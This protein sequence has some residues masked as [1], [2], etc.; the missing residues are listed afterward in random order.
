M[1]KSR[2]EQTSL[3][4]F[5]VLC[6]CSAFAASTYAVDLAQIVTIRAGFAGRYKVGL[7]TPLQ[8]IVRGGSGAASIGAQAT[9]ADSD[10]LNCTFNSA[11]PCQVPFGQEANIPLCVRFGHETGSVKIDILDGDRSLATKTFVSSPKPSPEQ[12]SEAMRPGQRLIVSVGAVP[13]SMDTS[14]PS[15]EGASARNVLAAIDDIADLPDCWQGYEG[16]DFL[17]LSTGRRELLKQAAS[18]PSRIDALEQWVQMGGTLVLTAGENAE[19]AFGEKSPL[20]RFVPGRF[21]GLAHLHEGQVTGLETLAHGQNPIPPPRPDEKVDLIAARL[22]NVHGSVDARASNI[23][24]VVRTAH[25]LGQVVFVATDLDR[26]SIRA[27]SDRPLLL[28]SLLGLPSNELPPEA[29]TAVE[30]YGYDDL[31]GQLRSSLEQFAGVRMVPFFVVAILAAIYILLIAPGDYFLLRR[32]RRGMQW[33]WITFPA[34]V[35]LVAAGGYLASSWLKRDV[36]RVDQVDLIDIDADGTARGATW[37]G[38]FSPRS[39]TFD[40]AL[41]AHLPNG[42]MPKQTTASLGWFGKAG[43]AF[44]GMYNRDAQNSGPIASEGYSIGPTMDTARDVPIQNWSCKNFVYRWL[45][46]AGDQG[47][48][49]S[50][51]EEGHQPAGSIVNDLKPSGADGNKGVTLSHAFLAYDGWAYLLGTIRPGETKEIGASTRRVSLSTFLSSESIEDSAAAQ[52]DKQP[53]DPGSRDAAYV[54]R[55]MLF[56]EAANGRKRTGMSND[57]QNFTDLSATFHTGR[58]VLVAMPPQEKS[59]RGA[60]IHNKQQPLS[61][62]LDKHTIIYRFVVPVG[63]Q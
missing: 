34:V 40:L 50:L 27:W 15:S 21:D 7:T 5:F 52:S 26:G 48:T 14:L 51:K 4:L 18:N 9:T 37:F 41:Q 19:A 2:K 6:F 58:A 23:P 8:V 31:A 13:G 54:L 36:I 55:A 42:A 10:G 62:P 29:K 35:V 12:V 17:I 44:N 49:I 63:K 32:L 24:L 38:V 3:R 60:D 33:T 56:Y 45:G 57:Y 20:A 16:V 11:A 1:Q 43:N 53:Y 59:Y 46:R 25:G 30:S 39:E 28:A 22:A 61:S 47:L